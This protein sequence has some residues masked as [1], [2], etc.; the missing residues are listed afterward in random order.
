MDN[1]SVNAIDAS[2]V[3]TISFATF[4]SYLESDLRICKNIYNNQFYLLSPDSANVLQVIT[5]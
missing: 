1:I 3:Y 5:F 4:E 2:N